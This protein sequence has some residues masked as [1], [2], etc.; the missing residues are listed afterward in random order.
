MTP[1]GV[2]KAA[3]TALFEATEFSPASIGMVA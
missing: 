2:R 3:P 1:R